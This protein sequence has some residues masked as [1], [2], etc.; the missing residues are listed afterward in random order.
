MEKPTYDQLEDELRGIRAQ[1]HL[2]E[3]LSAQLQT[4]NKDLQ[5][6]KKGLKKE[7]REMEIS[8]DHWQRHY[9]DLRGGLGQADLFNGDL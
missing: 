6:E 1:A 8:R 3:K 5:K 4:K 9:E 2:Y 7:L